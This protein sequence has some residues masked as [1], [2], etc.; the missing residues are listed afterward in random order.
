MRLDWRT[1]AVALAYVAVAV[2]GDLALKQG[3]RQMPPMDDASLGEVGRLFQHIFTTPLV[4]L[5]VG[6]LAVNFAIMLAVLSQA[7][8]SVVGPARA[9]SYLLLTILAHTVLHEHVPPLR[10]VGVAL[11]TV[12]VGMV[13]STHGAKGEAEEASAE[14]SAAAARPEVAGEGLAA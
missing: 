8:L 5:G 10:W 12:G 13:L 2:G 7:D 6:L 1:L 3:M 14:P 9:L 11:I 4:G